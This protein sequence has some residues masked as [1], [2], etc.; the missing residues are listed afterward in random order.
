MGVRGEVSFCDEQ[1][2][3]D[4]CPQARP[5]ENQARMGWSDK[6]KERDRLKGE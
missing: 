2:R 3:T 1:E 4:S 6:E 5:K